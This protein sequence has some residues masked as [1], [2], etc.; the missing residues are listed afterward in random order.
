MGR[1]NTWEEVDVVGGCVV[2][3]VVEFCPKIIAAVCFDA[4]ACAFFGDRSKESCDAVVGRRG[5]G[6]RDVSD[7]WE[8][9]VEA[10]EDE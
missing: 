9:E 6:A 2:E 5:G 10:L 3:L 8:E 4:G 7:R 1:E